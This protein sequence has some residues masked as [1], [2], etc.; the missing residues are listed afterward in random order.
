ME[1]PDEPELHDWGASK[2]REALPAPHTLSPLLRPACLC[3]HALHHPVLRRTRPLMAVFGGAVPCSWQQR[4]VTAPEPGRHP[5]PPAGAWALRHGACHRLHGHSAA[6]G[7]VRQAACATGLWGIVGPMPAGR[8][9]ALGPH[10][11]LWERLGPTRPGSWK[12]HWQ[13]LE[14]VLVKT[15]RKRASV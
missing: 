12:S 4:L 10:P 5:R 1:A 8:R 2:A 11:S 13:Q 3:S 14:N 7:G 15:N 9:P 6:L